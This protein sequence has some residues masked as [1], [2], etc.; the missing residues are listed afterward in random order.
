MS[1]SV[2]LRGTRHRSYRL[3]ALI[4]AGL[5]QRNAVLHSASSRQAAAVGDELNRQAGVRHIEVRP[6]HTATAPTSL[7]ESPR[8]RA[9]RVRTGYPGV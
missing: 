3:F 7:P 4:A 2:N 1:V 8:A 6:R 5:G 9:N